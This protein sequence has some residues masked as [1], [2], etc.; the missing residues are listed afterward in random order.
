M[1]G[2]DLD[3]GVAS[4]FRAEPFSACQE[5]EIGASRFEQGR[6]VDG[7]TYDDQKSA[8]NQVD[9]DFPLFRPWAGEGDAPEGG[10][11]YV[12]YRP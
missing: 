6:A 11:F 7:R 8:E 12:Q 9:H 1:G 2:A 4:G 3:P 5:V 10:A